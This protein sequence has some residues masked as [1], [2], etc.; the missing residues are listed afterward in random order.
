MM[1]TVEQSIERIKKELAAL[2]REKAWESLDREEVVD[3]MVLQ[4]IKAANEMFEE[5][6][7]LGEFVSSLMDQ[8]NNI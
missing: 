2:D 3:A 1:M 6:N 7:E 5:A 4:E 8:I